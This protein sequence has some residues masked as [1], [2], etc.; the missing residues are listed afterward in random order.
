MHK[1]SR[2]RRRREYFEQKKRYS[3]KVKLSEVMFN[4]R[5]KRVK[6]FR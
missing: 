4:L 3:L 5:L 6:T 2:T 1:Y